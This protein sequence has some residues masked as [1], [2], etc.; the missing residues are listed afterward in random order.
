M[1]GTEPFA[2]V[3]VREGRIVGEGINRSRQNFDPTS[4]GET[5]AI[6]NACMNLK[7][8]DLRGCDLYSSCEPCALCVAA[9]QISGIGRLY[10]AAGL[11]ESNE[12][13]EGVP[14]DN[15]FVGVD[16]ATLREECGKK[17]EERSMPS[18]QA[19]AEEA[20]AVILN[21]AKQAT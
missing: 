15:H 18:R 13:L 9:M 6:R 3:I 14:M 17:V 5:E 4:H 12:A 10:Y 21:W 7:T 1:P 20:I 16:A 8:V 11:S 2:A 19:L